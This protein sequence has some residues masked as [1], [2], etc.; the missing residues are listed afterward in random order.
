M[1]QCLYL[2][3]CLFCVCK[4]LF[5]SMHVGL[6]IYMCICVCMHIF[7]LYIF[8]SLCGCVLCMTVC[9]FVSMCGPAYCV[10]FESYVLL[11]FGYTSSCLDIFV[12]WYLYVYLLVCVCT[13]FC[14]SWSVNL[15]LHLYCSE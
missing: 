3:I 1:D 4:R 6:L 12:Y 8:M 11:L 10:L 5:F 15:R 9:I 7:K 2:Y 13:Y 14:V